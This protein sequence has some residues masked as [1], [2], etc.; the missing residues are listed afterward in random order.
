MSTIAGSP[1]W[2]R[3]RGPKGTAR[4]ITSSGLPVSPTTRT[5]GLVIRS[6]SVYRPGHT[7]MVAPGGANASA[8][9]I[10]GN[11]ALGHC[12]LSSSTTIPAYAARAP[13]DA[14]N[15]H[16]TTSAL[17][18]RRAN[19]DDDMMASWASAPNHPHGDRTP[20]P[21]PGGYLRQAVDDGSQPA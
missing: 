18:A 7:K 11:P 8:R 21:P 5:P 12:P 9:E 10:V 4:T 14:S 20:M 3:G 2:G 13:T 6:C 16:P 1:G 17:S 15:A 19:T